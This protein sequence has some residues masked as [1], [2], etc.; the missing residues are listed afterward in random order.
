MAKGNKKGN[1]KNKKKEPRSLEPLK[2]NPNYLIELANT[3]AR[4]VR[5][6]TELD[7]VIPRIIKDLINPTVN[8]DINFYGPY[9]LQQPVF[10]RLLDML[11]YLWY[12]NYQQDICYYNYLIQCGVTVNPP[13]AMV[14]T[15]NTIPTQN[16]PQYYNAPAQMQQV[17]PVVSVTVDQQTSPYVY[18]QTYVT[19]DQQINN[20]QGQQAMQPYMDCYTDLHEI[21][22]LLNTARA[23]QCAYLGCRNALVMM[24]NNY[25]MYGV[26]DFTPIQAFINQ[27][28]QNSRFITFPDFE[29]PVLADKVR[30]QNRNNSNHRN[31]ERRN[32]NDSR[33]HKGNTRL[34]HPKQDTV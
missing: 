31:N 27:N 4:N 11:Y 14:D 2:Q 33:S 22:K 16:G 13:S 19:P 6:G 20:G 25:M 17:T 29:G 5:G 1:N 15:V 21:T 34:P 7:P 23:N 10:G 32:N 3:P 28:I 8:T 26:I 9:L 24:Y 30:N 18:Q 12:I